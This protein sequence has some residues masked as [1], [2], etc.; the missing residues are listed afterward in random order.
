MNGT[1]YD[2]GSFYDEMFAPDGGARPMARKLLESIEALGEG[3][4]LGRQRAADRALMQLGIT[5]NVYG[6]AAGVEKIFPFGIIPRIL[7]AGE[8]QRIER[9]LSQR[10]RALNLF[11]DDI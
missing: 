9:G 7:S 1:R 2:L 8:W 6:A 4:L 5:F 3:E 11:L 10:I